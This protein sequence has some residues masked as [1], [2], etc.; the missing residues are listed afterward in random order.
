M[1]PDPTWPRLQPVRS[2]ALAPPF[3]GTHQ[4]ERTRDV[5]LLATGGLIGVR[6]SA[7]HYRMTNNFENTHQSP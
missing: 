1:L 2:S 6:P 3:T 4:T 5:C 7:A